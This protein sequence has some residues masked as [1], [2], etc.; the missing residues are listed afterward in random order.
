MHE[1]QPTPPAAAPN[2]STWDIAA[3]ARAL[4]TP[5]TPLPNAG[6]GEGFSF[7]V[8]EVSPFRP[9]RQV[10]FELIPSARALRLITPGLSVEIDDLRAPTT[11]LNQVVFE[12]QDAARLCHL[13]L[14]RKGEIT[15]LEVPLSLVSDAAQ[16]GSGGLPGE[17]AAYADCLATQTAPFGTDDYGFD[18]AE[19][20]RRLDAGLGTD[21]TTFPRT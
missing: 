15:L 3:I 17:D 2:Q 12:R 1:G 16:S 13:S 20:R 7:L 5:P 6:S 4:D 21:Q 9:F 14:T 11:T 19:L 8:G 10:I 18:E